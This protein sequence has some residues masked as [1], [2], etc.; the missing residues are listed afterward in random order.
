[1]DTSEEIVEFRCKNGYLCA[2]MGEFP[3]TE[4]VERG[5]YQ[6]TMSCEMVDATKDQVME[7]MSAVDSRVF[8]D[9]LICM[10][11]NKQKVIVMS[12]S[13]IVYVCAKMDSLKEKP[14]TLDTRMYVYMGFLSESR[15][16]RN[17][18]VRLSA[19][20]RTMSL[21]FARKVF[22]K[23]LVVMS[24]QTPSNNS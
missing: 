5:K 19:T 2:M 15:V 23:P 20:Q 24:N 3:R 14:T 4:W 12:L 6:P 1:M 13:D 7:V 17:S 18:E 8:V 22:G 11:I 16:N 21:D 10:S 9:M